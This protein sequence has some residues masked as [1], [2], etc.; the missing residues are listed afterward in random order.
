MNLKQIREMSDNICNYRVRIATL[1]AEVTHIINHSNED[2]VFWE[3]LDRQVIDTLKIPLERDYTEK[4][5]V[6]N[7]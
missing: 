1:E 2:E 6:V 4:G 3:H 5:K 7:K